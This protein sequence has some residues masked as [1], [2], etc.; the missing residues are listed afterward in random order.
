MVLVARLFAGPVMFIAGLNH[1]LNPHFYLAIMPDFVPFPREFNYAAGIA[2]MLGAI[3][4]SYPPT[5]RWGSWFLIATLV[6]VFPANV[7]M[8]LSP[9]RYD[10]IPH[11]VL[12]ARLPLQILFVYLV[13]LAGRPE[14]DESDGARA[15]RHDPC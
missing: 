2:E 11:G 13:W 10:H 8:A 12:L 14:P 3:A 7:H 4:V 5:R 15:L 1:F 6:A 9:D